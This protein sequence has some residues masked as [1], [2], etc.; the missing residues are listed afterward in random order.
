MA[1]ITI[2]LTQDEQTD[3]ERIAEERLQDPEQ[4]AHDLLVEAIADALDRSKMSPEQRAFNRGVLKERRAAVQA[5]RWT[6]IF[7]AKFGAQNGGIR[8]R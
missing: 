5:T 8:R 1:E 7:A 2:T 4:T 3:L 6:E